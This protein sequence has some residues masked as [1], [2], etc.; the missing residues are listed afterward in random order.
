MQ[1]IQWDKRFCLGVDMIDNQHQEIFRLFKNLYDKYTS[2][3]FEDLVDELIY[4]LD[5]YITYHFNQEEELQEFINY[6]LAEEHKIFH[7]KFIEE[8]NEYRKKVKDHIEPLY[9]VQGLNML[10]EWL[11]EHI[12][13]EDYKMVKF[14]QDNNY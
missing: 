14:I 8:F 12:Q 10:A 7:K 11:I 4:F 5:E 1:A 6:P 9:A 13:N 3:E 2:N